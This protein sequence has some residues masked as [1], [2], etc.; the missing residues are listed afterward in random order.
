VVMIV[1]GGVFLRYHSR[2]G[3]VESPEKH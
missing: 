3:N 2:R 1:I